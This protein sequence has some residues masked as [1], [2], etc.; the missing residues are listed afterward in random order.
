MLITARGIIV[1]VIK[2]QLKAPSPKITLKCGSKM[3][4]VLCS[5]FEAYISRNI[6]S[7]KAL[8]TKQIV[9]RISGTTNQWF[10]RY[11]RRTWV[12]TKSSTVCVWLF[13]WSIFLNIFIRPMIA[14]IS[15]NK[16]ITDTI[17]YIGR[18]LIILSEPYAESIK[19]FIAQRYKT[20]KDNS[21]NTASSILI[22]IL[23]PFV[24]SF[25]RPFYSYCS[26]VFPSHS[27]LKIILIV[28]GA[29]LHL[30]VQE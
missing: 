4:I 24:T 9:G 17:M 28:Y 21:K 5:I 10:C 8:R 20:G 18:L 11:F 2:R 26:F 1:R 23:T 13:L 6:H 14:I 15:N 16:I 25:H 12:S 27:R 7:V 3:S 30:F 29:L 19:I 22:I